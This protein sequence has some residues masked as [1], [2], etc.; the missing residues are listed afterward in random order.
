MTA[1]GRIGRIARIC[2]KLILACL[3]A[4]ATTLLF[5]PDFVPRLLGRPPAPS[6]RI[7]AADD[8]SETFRVEVVTQPT[9]YITSAT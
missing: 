7:P 9:N 1:V 3:L 8:G 5:A 4:L 2:G 6:W